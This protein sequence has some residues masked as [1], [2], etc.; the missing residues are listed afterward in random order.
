MPG[1]RAGDPKA[2]GGVA[3]RAGANAVS[4]T[5]GTSA[6]ALGNGAAA[7]AGGSKALPMLQAGLFLLACLI[8]GVAVAIVRPF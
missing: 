6:N 3:Q 1:S 7:A 2:A 5:A 8:G 4:E